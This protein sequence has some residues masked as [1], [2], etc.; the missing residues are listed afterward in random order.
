L[1]FALKKSLQIE[2][3]I[4]FTKLGQKNI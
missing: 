1:F 3:F 2:L 4:Y